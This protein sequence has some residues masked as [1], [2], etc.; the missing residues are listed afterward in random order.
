M[1]FIHGFGMHVPAR[2]VTNEKIAA[3]MGK[4]PDWIEGATGIR[5]RRWAETETSV[6]DLAVLAAQDCLRSSQIVP[7]MIIVASG[8]AKPGFPG[9][10]AEVAAR[11][12]YE[13]IPALDV[14]MASAGSLFG[15]ALASRMVESYGDVL[16]I[17]A[18]KMSAAIQNLE[19][20]STAILFGDGAGSVLIS[21]R[22]GRWKILNSV[23]HSDGQFR[24]ELTY[25][26]ASKLHMN[27]LSVI[28]Q[29]SRKI[30]AAIQ[31]A[32]ASANIAASDV[33]AFL[34]HQANHNLIVR[35]A[36]A[37][38][39]PGEKFYSNI[40]RYGNTSSASMLIAAAE[41]AA[42]SPQDGPIVFAAFGAGYHWG[43]LVAVSEK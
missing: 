39:V 41:W 19:D 29:A 33:T 32:L 15:M 17:G 37:L 24:D 16:V 25:D 26:G 13:G 21:N 5:E 12:G 22:P 43:A 34:M 42:N 28:M 3:S 20:P 10:A 9:P 1:A 11:L 6:A 2:V 4:T 30:P 38:E 27:G 23:L 18:E 31:E 8:T 7:G 14:P 40:E 35:V 36:K